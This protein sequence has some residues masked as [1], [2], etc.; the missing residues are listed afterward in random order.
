MKLK[1][2]KYEQCDDWFS[3]EFVPD[4]PRS[5]ILYTLEG[6]EAEGKYEN[7]KWIQY[8]WSCEV[9]PLYWREMPRYNYESKNSL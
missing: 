5:V 1:S 6:Q 4:N 2:V 3:S 8:R 9:N 7:G